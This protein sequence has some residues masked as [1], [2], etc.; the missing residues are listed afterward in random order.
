MPLIGSTID[1][2]LTILLGY[3]RCSRIKTVAER[4]VGLLIVPYLRYAPGNFD[5][6]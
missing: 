5:Y 2:F 1:L 4:R 3:G 6:Y